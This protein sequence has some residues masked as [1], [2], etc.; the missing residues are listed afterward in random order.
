[1]KSFSKSKKVTKSKSKSN[2][3]VGRNESTV[4]DMKK[5]LKTF[6]T[7][8][9]GNVLVGRVYA[10]FNFVILSILCALS[11]WYGVYLKKP[12]MLNN[13]TVYASTSGWGDYF[14]AFGTVLFILSF[15]FLL[16]VMY[17]DF[18][19]GWYGAAFFMRWLV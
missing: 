19:A 7:F 18:V 8:T 10:F 15:I 16:V 5:A 14:I 6:N 4:Q 11:I 17:S 1:M 12:K 9:T 13:N 2:G 3:V